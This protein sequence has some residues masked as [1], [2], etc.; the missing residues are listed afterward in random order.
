MNATRGGFESG[1]PR[2]LPFPPNTGISTTPQSSPDGQR[3]LVE[4]SQNQ[5]PAPPSINVVLNWPA[6]LKP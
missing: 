3:F 1:V 2:P 5:R 4:V 6:A